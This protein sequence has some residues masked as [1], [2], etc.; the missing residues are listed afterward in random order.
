[1]THLRGDILSYH[2]QSVCHMLCLS[3]EDSARLFSLLKLHF[4]VIQ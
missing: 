4:G 3:F 1:M 2:I